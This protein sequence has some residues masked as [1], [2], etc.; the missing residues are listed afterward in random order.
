MVSGVM[1]CCYKLVTPT[2][3]LY[4]EMLGVYRTQEREAGPPTYG[5]K[6]DGGPTHHP[7]I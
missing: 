3:Q 6:F 1:Y 2:V 5:S 7:K 4:V